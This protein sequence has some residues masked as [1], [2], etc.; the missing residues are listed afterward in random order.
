M[1]FALL[2]AGSLFLLRDQGH[3]EGVLE[4]IAQHPL[5]VSSATHRGKRACP[6]DRHRDDVIASEP[7]QREG[8]RRNKSSEPG[9]IGEISELAQLLHLS[10]QRMRRLRQEHQLRVHIGQLGLTPAE[11]F[12]QIEVGPVLIEPRVVTGQPSSD[13][14]KR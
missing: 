10:Y 2:L 6:D 5:S 1:R 4:L 9:Q 13:V 3:Q 7:R 8:D 11:A 12:R 14:R